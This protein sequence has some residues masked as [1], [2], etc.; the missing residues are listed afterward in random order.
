MQERS[1]ESDCIIQSVTK[2]KFLKYIDKKKLEQLTIELSVLRMT[3]R[4]QRGFCSLVPP[5]IIVVFRLKFYSNL[6]HD[7]H[8]RSWRTG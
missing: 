6:R 8:W 5:K 2:Q 4:L 1:R 7:F 3:N